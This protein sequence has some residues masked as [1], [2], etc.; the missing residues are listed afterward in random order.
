MISTIISFFEWI[1]DFMES[2]RCPMCAS[3][4]KYHGHGTWICMDCGYE[5]EY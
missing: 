2:S 4:L 5:E 1:G 3:K